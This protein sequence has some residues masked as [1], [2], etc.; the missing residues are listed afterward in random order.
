[1]YGIVYFRLVIFFVDLVFLFWFRDGSDNRFGAWYE[2]NYFV[3]LYLV[4]VNGCGGIGCGGILT[5]FVR[6][7][8][9]KDLSR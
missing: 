3:F 4:K 8:V 2:L 6:V 1:M 7:I 5:K 9:L